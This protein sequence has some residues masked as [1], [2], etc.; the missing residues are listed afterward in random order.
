[1]NQMHEVNR[2][3]WNSAAPGWQQLRDRDQ[4][5]RKCP[6]QP[7]LAFDGSALDL[8]REFGGELAGKRVCVTGSGDNYAAFA[9]TGMGATVTP[10]DI[11]E[12]QLRV[13]SL[14][15]EILGL[16]ITFVRT[17][18]DDLA[19][20]GDSGFLGWHGSSALG[21]PHVSVQ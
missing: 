3:H 15:A 1:M 10:T 11:S 17:D 12:Q 14:R 7:R 20:I 21:P 13:P 5:C 2:R 18:A 16:R 4:L 9:L 8:I 6:E 19:S